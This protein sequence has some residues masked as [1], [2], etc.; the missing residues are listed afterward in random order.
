M[1]KNSLI[2]FSPSV[3]MILKNKVNLF[4]AMIPIII[5]ILVYWFLGTWVYEGIMG[6]GSQQIEQYIS[7]NSFGSIVYYLIAT[8]LSIMLFFLVNWT[9]VLVVALIAS[10]FN[11]IMSARIEK[12][13]KKEEPLGFSDS[14]SSLGNNLFKTFLNEIKKITFIVI[15]TLFSLLFG[16]IPFLTPLSVL[17][18]VVLLAVEFLDFSWSRHGLTFRSCLRDIRKNIID[19]A[20]GGAFFFIIVSIP[21]LNLIVP[22][23]ATSYFTT[24]W[25][26][27]NEDRS[28]ASK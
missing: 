12:L 27:N 14:F 17:I 20:F 24:L 22:P 1:L 5:G 18:A 16:Y 21:I 7:S 23:L 8:I 13:L 26:K 3:K 15:L 4:L 28:K 10:P 6:W 25:V 11:D 2:S 19:Y 9:F